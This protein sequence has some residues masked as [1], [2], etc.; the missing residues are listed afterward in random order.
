MPKCP[1]GLRSTND[2]FITAG[3][4]AKDLGAEADGS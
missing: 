3:E 1:G 2:S 4:R